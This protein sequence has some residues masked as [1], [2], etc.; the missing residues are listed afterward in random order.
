MVIEC[1][2]KILF[3]P[4]NKTKKHE[5][6]DW[7]KV[8]MIILDCDLDKYYAWFLSNRFNLEFVKPLRG[9][10]VTFISER[11]SNEKF[12]KLAKKYNGKE[13]TFFYEIEPRTNIKHWWLRIHSPEAEAIRQEIGL[14]KE[15][16]FGLHLTIGYMNEKNMEHSEYIF[17]SIKMFNLI[18]SEPRKELEKHKIIKAVYTKNSFIKSNEEFEFNGKMVYYKNG[19]YCDNKTK[20]NNL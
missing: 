7:K 6:Q 2:G 11:I 5:K 18:S 15:P 16:Y 3:Q 17:N 19:H 12:N 8:A 20:L 14:N 13:I 4:E 9:G 1:K 10:H